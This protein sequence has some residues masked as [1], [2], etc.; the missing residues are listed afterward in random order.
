IPLAELA[1]TCR[2]PNAGSL[3]YAS[4]MQKTPLAAVPS[5]QVEWPRTG[6]NEPP[7]GLN[8]LSAAICQRIPMSRR[9]PNTSRS[10][11]DPGSRPGPASHRSP[12]ARPALL[13]IL[14]I[15]VALIVLVVHWPAVSSG[16]LGIDDD[17]YLTRNQLVRHPGWT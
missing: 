11:H 8:R 15:T 7:S 12:A 14:A 2:G 3:A 1:T 13:I 16:A 10:R 17:E 4:R 9:R 5:L 6:D